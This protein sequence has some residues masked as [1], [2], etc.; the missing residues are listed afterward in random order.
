VAP[1]GKMPRLDTAFAGTARVTGSEAAFDVVIDPVAGTVTGALV[2]PNATLELPA[3]ATV[4]VTFTSKPIG[5][6]SWTLVD[7]GTMTTANLE[8]TV[9]AS[10]AGMSV[11]KS[12]SPTR[13]AIEVIPA[14]TVILF[15]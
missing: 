3:S 4:N 11:I 10:V 8:W 1:A 14:G 5:G 12:V 9:N 13:V 6:G 2:A 7:V 15:R